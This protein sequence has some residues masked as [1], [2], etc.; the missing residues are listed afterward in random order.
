MKIL[1]N[2][3]C[4]SLLQ[5]N[6]WGHIAYIDGDKP[7]I[8][9]TTY[10]YDL[11]KNTIIAYSAPGHKIDSFRVRSKVCLQIDQV[12]SINNWKSVLVHGKF[13]ELYGAEAKYELHNFATGVKAIINQKENR[14]LRFISEFSSNIY[15]KGITIVYRIIIQDI[16]GR[17]M[18]A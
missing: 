3:D 15:S 7:F 8:I 12:N 11:I 2:N 1:E 17:Q 10:Y 6:Y 18:D 16:T 13:E 14:D 9:P 5:E 4:K